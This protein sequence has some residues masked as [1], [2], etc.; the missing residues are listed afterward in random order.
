MHHH[1]LVFLII[2]FKVWYFR[3]WLLTDLLFSS[4]DEFTQ[5]INS[6]SAL[7]LNWFYDSRGGPRIRVSWPFITSLPYQRRKCLFLRYRPWLELFNIIL[8]WR[9]HLKP[10][11][12]YFGETL[13]NSDRTATVP[14]FSILHRCKYVY[15]PRAC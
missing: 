14:K 1:L 11:L 13:A 15:V 9:N 7:F 5:F 2:H 12:V 6:K 10:C 4:K 3:S 8:D